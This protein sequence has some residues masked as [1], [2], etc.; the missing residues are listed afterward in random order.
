M[1]ITVRSSPKPET[2]P[3]VSPSDYALIPS[4][5]VPESIEDSIVDYLC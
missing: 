5:F 3:L 2:R 1:Q 4:I